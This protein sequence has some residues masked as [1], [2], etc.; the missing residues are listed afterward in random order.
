MEPSAKEVKRLSAFMERLGLRNEAL[1]PAT[2]KYLLGLT[3]E[4]PVAI[5]M[6]TKSLG[7]KFNSIVEKEMKP[8]KGGRVSFPA[9]YFGAPASSAYSGGGSCTGSQLITPKHID[10]MRTAYEEKFLRRLRM[11]SDSKKEMLIRMNTEVDRQVIQAAKE[12]M[13]KV[14][15]KALVGNIIMD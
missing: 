15:K 12:N 1:T 2:K 10:H 6:A 13:G 3:Q 9:E 11:S 14:T 4:H 5:P 7:K 8:M